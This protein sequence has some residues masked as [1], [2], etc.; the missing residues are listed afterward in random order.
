MKEFRSQELQEFRS[1]CLLGENDG[2]LE[3]TLSAA[4][5]FAAENGRLILQLLNSCNS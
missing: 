3:S 1:F 5:F 4:K 2:Y